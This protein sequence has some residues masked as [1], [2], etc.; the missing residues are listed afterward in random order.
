VRISDPRYDR[1][2]RR[3]D[4]ALKLIQLEVRTHTISLWTGMSRYRIQTL[5]REYPD[6]SPSRRHRG[7]PPYQPTFFTRSLQLECESSAF[8]SIALR[9][10]VIP[11]EII[12]NAAESLPTLQRGEQLTDAYVLYRTLYGQSQISMEHAML[13][14]A[15]LAERRVLTLQIC[16]TCQGLM[17]IDRFANRHRVCAFCR[18]N[19]RSAHRLEPLSRTIRHAEL[20]GQGTPLD[21]AP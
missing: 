4:L 8:A 15:E 16:G 6:S 13:L 14:V 19:G 2:K 12:A 9:M 18:G 3:Y 11:S 7:V 20:A 21:K 17:V 5:F 10:G 1:D